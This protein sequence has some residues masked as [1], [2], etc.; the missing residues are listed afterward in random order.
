MSSTL[1]TVAP[2]G[3]ESAK[4]DVPAL[5]VTLGELL[6]TARACEAAGAA[7]I[8][9]H[10]RD[11]ET[12][13]TLDPGLLRET[14]AALRETDLVVQLSTGGSVHDPY[15]DRLRV[16]DAAPDA[17]SLTCG[18]V[19]FGDDVFM[20]PW[21]FVAELYQE[22][23]ARGIVPEFELFDLGHVATMNRLLDRYGPPAGGRVHCDLVMGVPGGFTGDLRTVAAAVGQLPPGATWSATG[24]GR[25][26]LPVMFAA[27]AGGGHLRVGME[28]TLTYA[29]GRPVR[30]NEE[31]VARAAEAA[32]LAQRPPMTTTEA[33][34]FL[35]VRPAPAPGPTARPA[36]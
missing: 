1:I 6:A 28:D 36:P 23:Q 25:A 32:R 14:V 17:C 24:I 12:R 31:L 35:G 5:P 8:H 3:A 22:T 29:K 34:D 27:L 10:V 4:A 13:P 19:N 2:T 7:V 21:G 15:T 11:A 33:R 9:V 20:N 30:G 26:A 16:L 18:T